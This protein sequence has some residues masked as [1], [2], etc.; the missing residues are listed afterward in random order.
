MQKT[1]WTNV[2]ES[3]GN[4]RP[5]PGGYVLKI[6]GV[7]DYALDGYLLF[8][9]DYAEGD[10]F[11]DLN[12][13]LQET[14]GWAYPTF[15]QYYKGKS[16]GWFK[17]LLNTLERSNPGQFN[18][19][20]WQVNSDENQFKNLKFGALMG[21]EEYIDKKTGEIKTATKIRALVNAADIRN[22]NFKIP[23]IK[24]LD[25]NKATATTSPTATATP[26]A[27]TVDNSCPF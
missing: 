13:A 9:W 11:V 25:P 17:H 20:A 4:S 10:G 2:K 7:T 26:A 22:G 5:G 6:V 24:K 12:R 23:V 16:E 27:G 21:D 19:A 8:Q 18:V 14:Q 15:R 1:D 3:T